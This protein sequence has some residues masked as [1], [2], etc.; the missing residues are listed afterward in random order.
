MAVLFW[1][2]CKGNFGFGKKMKAIRRSLLG[3]GG[4]FTGTLKV[5]SASPRPS[6][7]RNG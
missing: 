1:N 4:K 5:P 3:I 6:I 7:Q 2:Y